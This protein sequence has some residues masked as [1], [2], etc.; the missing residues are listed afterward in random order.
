MSSYFQ[1]SG[2]AGV[3]KSA[4]REPPERLGEEPMLSELQLFREA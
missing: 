3:G 2:V 1:V 4:L